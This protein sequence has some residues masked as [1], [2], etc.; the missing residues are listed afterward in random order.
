MNTNIDE[1]S[2]IGAGCGLSPMPTE[3]D[4]REAWGREFV[5]HA[6][7]TGTLEEQHAMQL[8]EAGRDEWDYSMTPAEAFA[9]EL[10][11]WSDDG[12]YA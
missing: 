3:T 11:Y 1:P 12:D 4:R 5:L 7:S 8:F 2:V 6:V 9:E 10:S